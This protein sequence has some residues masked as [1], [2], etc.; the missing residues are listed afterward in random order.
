MDKIKKLLF[1]RQDLKYKAFHQKLIPNIPSD[2]V[3]GVRVPDIRQLAKNLP[4]GEKEEFLNCLPHK[5]YEENMLHTQ[6]LCGIKDF[7]DCLKK[8]KIFLTFVDNW[9]VCDSLKPKVFNK[10]K[11]QLLKEIKTWLKSHK[12]YE[13]RFA[14]LMLM[15]HFLKENFSDEIF[16]LVKNIKSEEYYINMMIAW[17]FAT[18]LCYQNEKV[19]EIL[20]SKTLS[21][22]VHN[23]TIQKA[24]ESFRISPQQKEFLKTL[25]Q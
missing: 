13:V 1:E 21:V 2:L 9:A 23:K 10:N 6:I 20:K 22:W 25:K 24:V 5:F 8:V 18:A 7:D 12:T 15:T 14:V 11:N 17:F 19:I 3:I 16:D 4:E